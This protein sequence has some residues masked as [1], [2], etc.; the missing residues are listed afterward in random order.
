MDELL[1]IDDLTSPEAGSEITFTKKIRIYPKNSHFVLNKQYLDSLGIH[2]ESNGDV[3][4]GINLKASPP[5]FVFNLSEAV[6]KKG[7]NFLAK[8]VKPG[9]S[10]SKSDK[11]LVTKLL[12]AS[13]VDGEPELKNSYDFILEYVAD[14]DHGKWF[15]F[16]PVLWSRMNEA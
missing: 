13:G 9:Y 7:K 5:L 1:N 3:A 16:V 15:R 12:V 6:L 2:L 10:P 4:F 8:A 14:N 11:K